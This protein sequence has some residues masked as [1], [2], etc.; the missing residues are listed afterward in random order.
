MKKT[1]V[2]PPLA[3]RGLR[4]G[5]YRRV[6]RRKKSS[7]KKAKGGSVKTARETRGPIMKGVSI[8]TRVPR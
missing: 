7:V 6:E 4:E 1:R 8:I 3:G 5:S 2:L